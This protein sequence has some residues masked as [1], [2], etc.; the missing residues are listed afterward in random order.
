M[1][2]IGTYGSALEHYQTPM[3]ELMAEA[4]EQPIAQD[5]D[6]LNAGLNT[7]SALTANSE[8]MS[9]PSPFKPAAFWGKVLSYALPSAMVI[10][11]GVLFGVGVLAGGNL[12]IMGVGVALFLASIPAHRIISNLLFCAVNEQGN[13]AQHQQAP[14]PRPSASHHSGSSSGSE[15]WSASIQPQVS[16]QTGAV[17]HDVDINP[18]SSLSL[19]DF[20]ALDADSDR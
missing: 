18:S 11:G 3:D 9:A 8:E 20:E 7:H 5:E 10:G 19:A 17:Q 12:A 2:N 6:L 4:D 16:E 15:D 14:R 1:S 13:A